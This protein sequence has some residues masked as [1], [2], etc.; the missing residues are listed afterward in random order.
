MIFDWNK[1]FPC[2]DFYGNFVA[3]VWF[4]TSLVHGDFH[5]ATSP[6]VQILHLQS[7]GPSLIKAF[8]LILPRAGFL[9]LF[10]D[11]LFRL[12]SG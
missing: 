11:S 7:V 2:Q 10:S 8:D 12:E 1:I 3:K 5:S 9:L 4:E 6:F